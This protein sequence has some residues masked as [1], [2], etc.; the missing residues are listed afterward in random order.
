M[1]APSDA[2]RR[3]VVSRVPFE[4]AVHDF[5][6]AAVFNPDDAFAADIFVC[7]KGFE[8]RATWITRQ[9]A[10]RNRSARRVLVG[11]YVTNSED[12]DER[13]RELEP[14][15]R[16]LSNEVSTF[17]ADSPAETLRA[18]TAALDDLQKAALTVAIDIS[19]ASSTLI[20]SVMAALMRHASRPSVTVMY[21][22]ARA[23][24]PD[25]AL[26]EPPAPVLE[27]T[28]DREQGVRGVE[29][30]ELFPG[31]Y[32]E[33]RPPFALVFAGVTRDRTQRCLH[34]LGEEFSSPTDELVQWIVPRPLDG[35][36]GGRHVRVTEIVTSLAP[37]GRQSVAECDARD[38]IGAA[39]MLIEA[40][41]RHLGRNVSLI[42]MGAKF[43]SVGLALALEARAEV[44]LV[45]ARPQRFSAAR[46]S[47]GVD[48]AWVLAL[49]DVGDLV[50]RLRQVGT[51]RIALAR[52]PT[53]ADAG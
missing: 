3:V 18:V 32:H 40:A 53:R 16:A 15:L 38:Y 43:Q 22:R 21:T 6:H 35:N 14:L 2:P 34:Y 41:D 52:T 27:P 1:T 7:A 25:V 48:Q 12:N 24:F 5:P 31:I 33:A 36:R 17:D 47:Q 28:P 39:R 9:L 45:Y 10:E 46:Y 26:E 30:S 37:A 4:E 29:V 19:G 20:F 44:G 49:G 51:L 11:T 13:F 23:Y 50:E 42:H 8:E